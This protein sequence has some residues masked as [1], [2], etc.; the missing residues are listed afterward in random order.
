MMPVLNAEGRYLGYYELTDLMGL[1]RE[2]PFIN[3]S[4]GVLIV[5]REVLILPLAKYHK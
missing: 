1:F 3:E 4:G 2:T 5:E